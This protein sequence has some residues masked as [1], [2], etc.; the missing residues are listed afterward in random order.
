MAGGTL[1]L[2]P[3][4]F[5]VNHGTFNLTA[6]TPFDI[7]GATL[8][9]GGTLNLSS[10]LLSG[11]TGSLVNGFGGT[12][13]GPGTITSGFSNS[14]G[15][16]VVGSGTTNITHAF[17]SSG[18]IQL[19]TVTSNLVG[20]TITNNGTINGLGNIGSA[21]T[22]TAGGTLEALGNVLYVSGALQNQAG[23]LIRVGAGSKLVIVQG[24]ATNVGVINLSGGIFD[25]NGHPLNN[26]GQMS[27]F[28]TFATGGAGLDNN[29]TVT[30]FGGLTNVNG[31]VTN[32]NG[33]T[34]VVA[35]N[36]AI[37]T[38]LVTNNGGGTFNIVS[39]TAVFAGGSSGSFSGTFTNNASSAF[40]VGGSGVL[41]VDGAPTL[42][43]A[44][45][46]AVG[47][48]STLQ[49]KPTT[50]AATVGAGVTATVASGA[51][52]ELA[53][54]V[55]SLSSG[56]NRVNITNSSSSPGIL[57][58]GTNQQVGNIDG[59]GA[60]QVNAGS[61]LTANLIV[62]SALVIGGTAGSPGLLTIDA[63]DA[64]GNPLGQ[65]SGFEL[66]GSLVP[67]GP[68]GDVNSSE[69]MSSIAAD[70]TELAVPAAGNSVEIGNAS[71]VPEPS[72]ILLGLLAVLGVVSTH[73]ARHYFQCRRTS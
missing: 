48:T 51:T 5:N 61:D 6:A 70:S 11:A 30:F 27:G 17:A 7:S 20:G 49:F 64:S 55:S 29:G 33:K 1:R 25:N 31:A 15:I 9:N 3:G 8:T 32:E 57:V 68:F 45:S 16:V 36:P 50:G 14:G 59:A 10:G 43:A 54:S 46:M 18:A 26:T 44:S 39:T 73:F 38:G 28:G 62:Q 71:Q 65:P 66:A 52:L 53:G 34:I 19:T 13:V 67:S 40:S 56:A 60:T 47:G 35:Y 21:V 42:G 4:P 23:G 69:S 63:S 24:L 72:T 37:F 2:T 41:E 22:N 58:S 12:L